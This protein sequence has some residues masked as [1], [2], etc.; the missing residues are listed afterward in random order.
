MAI[1]TRLRLRSFIQ[2]YLRTFWQLISNFSPEN[3]GIFPQYLLSPYKI[4]GTI[5]TVHG[6]AIEFVSKTKKQEIKVKQTSR[7]IEDVVLPRTTV[8]LPMFRILGKQCTIAT[9]TLDAGDKGCFVE[10][11]EEGDVK[12]IEVRFLS[13][14]G[15]RPQS[16]ITDCLWIFG[17]N[18]PEHLTL[19]IAKRRAIV[20][21]NSFIA[22]SMFRLELKTLEENLSANRIIFEKIEEPLSEFKRL[23]TEGVKE[24]KLKQFL[25]MSQ[26]LLKLCFHGKT[27]YPEYQLGEVYQVDFVEECYDGRYFLI[28]LESPRD[29][30][31]T[32]K[33]ITTELR[34]AI[35]QIQDY[36]RWIGEHVGYVKEKLPSMTSAPRGVVIIGRKKT[37]SNVNEKKLRKLNETLHLIEVLTFDDIIERVKLVLGNLKP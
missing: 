19:E 1:V 24:E 31:Y 6:V 26:E 18:L 14:F 7:R 30:L 12:F 22:S 34:N 16:K 9:L 4:I 35:Q 23:V 13:T 17:S 2:T 8:P 20:D 25:K 33:G 27:L 10:V 11:A 32:L 29:K 28:E 21:F 5:S 15:G 37:L 36:Q 3:R